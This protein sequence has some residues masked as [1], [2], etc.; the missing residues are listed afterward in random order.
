MTVTHSSNQTARIG[1]I[2]KVLCAFRGATQTDVAAAI[3][4]DPATVTRRIEGRGQ[5]SA[6]ELDQLARY[7]DV[8][9]QLFFRDP[10][11]LA[12]AIT[13]GSS[14]PASEAG[15]PSPRTTGRPAPPLAG[16]DTVDLMAQL[17]LAGAGR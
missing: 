7:F 1:V 2:V 17:E 3:G 15:D 16:W 11:D 9:V 5:W 14:P 4:R 8:P 12:D 6:G 10:Q 13:A